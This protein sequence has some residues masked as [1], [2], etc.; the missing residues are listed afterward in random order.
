MVENLKRL[1]IVDNFM[2]E[3][4]DEASLTLNARVYLSAYVLK[5]GR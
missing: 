1:I 3:N 2:L 5:G 4:K